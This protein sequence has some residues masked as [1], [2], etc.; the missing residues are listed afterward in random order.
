MSQEFTKCSINR[1]TPVQST[2]GKLSVK[3]L[4]PCMVIIQFESNIA[5]L[6]SV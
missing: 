5:S 3:K 4:S 1:P 2:L 6:V